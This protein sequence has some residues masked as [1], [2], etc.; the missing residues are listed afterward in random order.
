MPCK[1][2]L[3]DGSCFAQ[4]KHHGKE[5]TPVMARCWLGLDFHPERLQYSRHFYQNSVRGL[6][7]RQ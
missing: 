6:A 7:A 1:T 3:L 2:E 4:A 5:P